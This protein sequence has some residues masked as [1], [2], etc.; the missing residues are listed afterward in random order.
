MQLI[1]LVFTLGLLL[2]NLAGLTVLASR[3][4][5]RFALARAA[6]VLLWVMV[7]FFVE[8]FVGLGRLAWLWPLTSAASI[9]LI[10]RARIQLAER[11]FWRSELI[12]VLAFGYGLF[13]RMSFPA[14]YPSSERVTD[15][16]FITNY[17]SGVTLPPPDLWFPPGKFDFYYAMQH[18]GAALMARILGLSSGMS[19]NLAFPLVMAMPITLAWDYASRFVTARWP[20]VVLIAALAI[21][22]TG[23]SPIMHI[24]SQD[25]AGMDAGGVVNQFMWGSQRFIG[26]YDQILN[27]PA[28]HAL[29]PRKAGV[30][31]DEV[32]ELPMEN[33]GYQF[34]L[35]DYHP[36]LG[37]FYL[38][39]L[40]I[41]LIGALEVRREDDANPRV[42]QAL[43]GLSVSAVL[44]T[45]T[46]VFPLQGLLV[47]AWA[48]WR[49]WHARTDKDAMPDW[50]AL[51]GGGLLGLALL[52]PFLIGIAN[53]AQATPIKL[54]KAVDHAPVLAF[55]FQHWPTLLFAA[56]GLIWRETRKTVFVMALV[57]GGLM[58]LSEFI[59]VDDVTGGRYERTNTTM[60]WWGWIHSGAIIAI[61]APLLASSRR[62]VGGVVIA[63][64][65]LMSTYAYDQIRY[66]TLTGKSE[67]AKLD[68]HTLY[69][70]DN[71]VRDMY[72]YLKAAPDG[73]VL[74]NIYG[75]S[76]T[77]S[78]L[79]A[80]F[81]GKPVLL[82]WPM[83]LL[84]WHAGVDHMWILKE[85]I[86][87]FYKGQLPDA[88]R[89]L[90]AN[91]VRYIVF[92][93]RDA[94]NNAE[95]WKAIQAAIGG[96]Y[97]WQDF[98]VAGDYRVGIWTRREA[99]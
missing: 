10:W 82:G 77:E 69:T 26:G 23:V 46:W 56:L 36:P 98:Y 76:F 24:F 55:L 18:Y 48:G 2:L 72:A 63:A 81:A 7:F 49:Q 54:V 68:A 45:N 79:Y 73:I 64:S 78:G 91:K 20:R 59:Y 61:G 70:R 27:T 53:A 21:G 1:N 19:Y 94:G 35:G 34:Y 71:T 16:Y 58:L 31:Q 42:L 60:K 17:L 39:L 28:G 25:P 67:F 92:N 52:Y 11:G 22:G 50:A 62:W 12:F 80:L 86:E 30:S 40:A 83:H 9:W 41:A 14:I 13:W 95:G 74:E 85:Q 6:G 90:I 97:D 66:W 5:P 51:V 37:G 93:G 89:W 75:G 99:Q 88:Q 3:W 65:L 8:H 43:L 29:F 44:A 4:I 84:T 47:A 33:Y 87:T 15:L 96:S 57:F 32:R 38:L